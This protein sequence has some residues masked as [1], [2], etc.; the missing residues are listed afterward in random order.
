MFVAMNSVTLSSPITTA[1][2]GI[3]QGVARLDRAAATVAAG[4]IGIEPVID[5]IVAERTVE[6]NAAVVRSAD[7]MHKTLID[8]LV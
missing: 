1:L 4:D 7:E 6:Q 8:I 2:S 5:M 3:Q